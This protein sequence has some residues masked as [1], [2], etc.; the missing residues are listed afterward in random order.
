MR[1]LEKYL[2]NFDELREGDTV[3]HIV[4]QIDHMKYLI[5]LEKK[6]KLQNMKNSNNPMMRIVD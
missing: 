4:V 1:N 2:I 6:W 5:L 3:Y